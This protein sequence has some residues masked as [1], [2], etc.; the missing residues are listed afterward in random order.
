MQ[1]IRLQLY[2]EPKILRCSNTSFCTLWRICAMTEVVQT[3]ADVPKAQR[4][5][6]KLHTSGILCKN[7]FRISFPRQPLTLQPFALGV[8]Q[9]GVQI[10]LCLSCSSFSPSYSEVSHARFICDGF[11]L[12][13]MA[14]NEW[15]TTFFHHL[16][17]YRRTQH[18]HTQC[19][20]HCTAPFC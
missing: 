19:L 5:S 18:T 15:F 20:T 4:F 1:F 7:C 11:M 17:T 12:W 9:H 3:I 10:C 14:H 8:F 16:Y 2:F 13:E 6:S